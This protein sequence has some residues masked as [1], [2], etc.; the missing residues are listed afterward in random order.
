MELTKINGGNIYL[1]ANI[2][3]YAIEGTLEYREKITALFSRISETK[4]MVIT[5]ELTLAECLVKPYSEKDLVS[6]S[7]YEAYIKTSSF[8]KEIHN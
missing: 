7:K 4:S 2:F 3:I 8:L 5:S 1:D 6:V